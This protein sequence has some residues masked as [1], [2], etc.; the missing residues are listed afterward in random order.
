MSNY[1]G[2]NEKG[3]KPLESEVGLDLFDDRLSKRLSKGI[4]GKGDLAENDVSRVMNMSLRA[5]PRAI[6]WLGEL[7]TAGVINTVAAS[8]EDLHQD[9]KANT[10]FTPEADALTLQINQQHPSFKA[11]N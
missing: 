7:L 8:R 4:S 3:V 10:E 2:Q 9:T 11:N 1:V 6:Y 5:E